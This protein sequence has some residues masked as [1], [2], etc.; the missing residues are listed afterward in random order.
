MF[1]CCETSVFAANK[2]EII[3]EQAQLSKQL[4]DVDLDTLIHFSEFDFYYDNK[5]YYNPE[6]SKLIEDLTVAEKHFE[7]SNVAVSYHEYKSILKTMKPNDFYYMLLAYKL[8]QIG[9]FSLSHEAMSKVE[10]REIWQSHTT[11]IRNYCFPKVSLKIPEEVFLAELLA[12][13]VYNNMSDES[14]KKLE[15]SEK[16]LLNSDYASYIRSKA[17]FSE[18]KYKRALSEIN[19]ALEQNPNNVNYLEYKAQ[20]LGVLNKNSDAIK[21]LNLINKD[22]VIFVET[23]K[24]IEKIKSYTLSLS[25]KGEEEKKYNLAYYFYLN[26]DYQRAINELNTLILKGDKGKSPELLGYIYKINDKFD[27]AEKL[28]DR[29]ILKN[30]KN[31][32]AHKGKGDIFVRAGNYKQALDEYKAA[33]KYNKND[34]ET[35]VALTVT[36]YKTGDR[37]SALKYLKKAQRINLNNFKVL[38]LSS[39]LTEDIGKQ[40]L[41]SSLKYNPFY[42]E[43]WLD[44]AESALNTNDTDSAEAYINIAAFITKNSPRYFYYKSIL[45]LQKG[46]LTTAESDIQHAKNLT[47]Q[48]EKTLYEEI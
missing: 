18:K 28:Y 9:F 25:A 5:L 33:Y 26:K 42:P 8:S 31:A 46:E 44:L 30:R 36:T 14:L 13:I 7:K 32:F 20:I 38:Y 48:K 2:S 41:K 1:V 47:N 12:D 11:A 45:N 10:D 43:G 35:L 21:T 15:N 6:M 23:H 37:K 22:E 27:D 29:Y 40:Y 39:K 3:K 16:I 24:N 34:I 17:Y 4:K 19:T